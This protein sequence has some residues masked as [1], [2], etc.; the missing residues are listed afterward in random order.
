MNQPNSNNSFR[1]HRLKKVPKSNLQS[2]E[3]F[4]KLDGQI[5]EIALEKS[6]SNSPNRQEKKTISDEELKEREEKAK[7]L[8]HK[9]NHDR[10][11]RDKRA[12]ILQEE[13]D[14][15]IKEDF[16]VNLIRQKGL[17]EKTKEE[18][19][20]KIEERLK[21]AEQKQKERELF[22]QK[23]REISKDKREVPLFK[24][25]EEN[26]EKQNLVELE[27]RKKL[28]QERRELY[29]PINDIEL[30]EHAEKHEHDMKVKLLHKKQEQ[31]IGNNQ[32]ISSLKPHLY[33]S[34]FHSLIKDKDEVEK[35][36][37]FKEKEDK[38]SMKEK[39]SQYSQVVKELYFPKINRE[40]ESVSKDI[41]RNIVIKAGQAEEYKEDIIHKPYKI[42]IKK[43]FKIHS[44]RELLSRNS[45]DKNDIKTPNHSDGESKSNEFTNP[46]ISYDDNKGTKK[47]NVHT[48]TDQNHI[49]KKVHQ[50]AKAANITSHDAKETNADTENEFI[51]SPEI[52]ESPIKFKAFDA[53]IKSPG[54]RYVEVNE[55]KIKTKQSV[56][57]ST[58]NTSMSFKSKPLNLKKP[59]EKQTQEESFSG[60]EYPNYLEDM[61]KK[62][63]EQEKQGILPK[64]QWE[65]A[66]KDNK[67]SYKDKVDN[68]LFDA[69]RL[70]QKAKRKEEV[71]KSGFSNDD[72]DDDINDIYMES[73]KAK[74]AVL[75]QWK[76]A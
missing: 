42:R 61:K 67:L 9:L 50:V 16:S 43:Q 14:R 51:I 58:K 36:K 66:L 3:K 21:M 73:I 25:I 15:K 63:L 75:Q 22:F 60:F 29:K 23:D 11:E 38:K 68:I 33:K 6:P 52:N 27:R 39:Q 31:I 49:N 59:E 2:E 70:E 30:K 35:T 28:L 64:N 56:R 17:D 47:L 62:R 37:E 8:I 18:K 57:S 55:Q 4:K 45:N 72:N 71:R 26:S 69:K 19:K 65:K 32:Q 53:I 74:L 46:N 76:E 41:I 12:H 24:K 20:K 48:D 40:K 13:F 44:K 1:S 34:K 54:L 7:N 5:D 10:K